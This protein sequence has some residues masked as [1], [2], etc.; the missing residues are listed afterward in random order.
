MAFNAEQISQDFG[1]P[2]IEIKQSLSS[3]YD[4]FSAIDLNYEF[5]NSNVELSNNN[6]D[7]RVELG[8]FFFEEDNLINDDF[9]PIIG[10]VIFRQLPKENL[11]PNGDC[12][13]FLNSFQPEIAIAAGS[14]L[15]FYLPDNHWGY[16]TYDGV[17]VSALAQTGEIT[18]DN[19][20]TAS[21]RTYDDG[22]GYD[23]QEHGSARHKGYVKN[24]EQDSDYVGPDIQGFSGFAGYFPYHYPIQHLL[25]WSLSNVSNPVSGFFTNAKAYSEGDY[26]ENQ[27]RK[28]HDFDFMDPYDF[29]NIAKWIKTNDAYSYGRCLEFRSKDEFE[30]TYNNSLMGSKF[31]WADTNPDLE[32]PSDTKLDFVWNDFFTDN[33]YNYNSSQWDDFVEECSKF[34]GILAPNSVFTI[35]EIPNEILKSVQEQIVGMFNLSAIKH[36]VLDRGFPNHS[37]DILQILFGDLGHDNC[38]IINSEFGASILDDFFKYPMETYFSNYEFDRQHFFGSGG[39]SRISGSGLHHNL[40]YQNGNEHFNINEINRSSKFPMGGSRNIDVFPNPP[41]GTVITPGIV[42]DALDINNIMYDDSGEDG[43]FEFGLPPLNGTD[44]TNDDFLPNIEHLVKNCY[45]F[46]VMGIFETFG[47]TSIYDTA[48]S[49][50]VPSALFQNVNYNQYRTLNHCVE[51]YHPWRDD[52]FLNPYSSLE[53]RFKMRTSA[54]GT[55][56]EGWENYP[57]GWDWPYDSNNPPTLEIGVV[58]HDTAIG[59][60]T[61]IQ[62]NVDGY[63]Y[64]KDFYYQPHGNF[65][66]IRYDGKLNSPN[67]LDAKTSLFGGGVRVTNQVVDEW[68][69]FSYIFNLA[70]F[71]SYWAGG[72]YDTAKAQSLIIQASGNFRGRV[73]VDDIEVFESHKFYPDVDVRKKKSAN[74]YGIGDLTEYYDPLL[75]PQE[76]EDT[77]GPLEAQFYF[78]PTYPTDEIFDIKRTPMYEEF[79]KGMFY[80]YDVDWGDGTP[81]EFTSKPEQISEEKALYHTYE[82]SGIFEVVG[83]MIRLKPDKEDN[84]LG[85]V[86]NQKFRLRI[87]IN[88]GLDEDFTYFGSDGFS[89]IPFKK[90][91]PILGGYSKQSI[92]YKSISR[93]LGFITDDIKTNIEFKND[94]QKLKTE[95]ALVKMDDKLKSSLDIL[96]EYTTPRYIGSTLINNGL[97]VLESELG[98]S[99][100]DMDMT[101]IKCYNSQKSMPELL[102]FIGDG[103]VA[104]PGSKRYWKNIISKNYTLYDREGINMQ[105][106]FPINTSSEQ[107]WVISNEGVRPYYPVLPKYGFDGKF[108]PNNFPNQ[109]IPFPQ[110]GPITEENEQSRD[111]IINLSSTQNVENN[112]LDDNSGNKNLGFAFSDFKPKFDNKTLDVKKRKTLNRFT[113]TK[114]NGAF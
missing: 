85:I 21:L 14:D 58:D 5:K 25:N 46:L 52:E 79:K 82:T 92:Y 109:N 80:I 51:F 30:Y 26:D 94:G 84:P 27:Q 90:T 1:V 108:I 74:N 31:S 61:R 24:F 98:E 72:T 13:F 48:F 63:G 18:F 71:N 37:Y 88:E 114:T 47:L 39:M 49:S 89:F 96:N 68:E 36:G 97:T 83:Y 22:L 41:A 77:T 11:I 19:I 76:Y 32:N 8:M 69:Q 43:G 9:P 34:P 15:E 62:D 93:Q 91:T 50:I 35:D 44:Y 7:G 104:N 95:L 23:S 54:A 59:I 101:S 86:Y 100:G 56:D 87:N 70:T 28:S 60:P 17:G 2:E 57:G 110:T 38:G 81:K 78:Y 40:A 55:Y 33:P 16:C 4:I 66:S 67:T 106:Q 3:S 105:N 102:G 112:V 29:S 12:K 103:E 45:P 6:Q 107:E 75:Q 64:P 42:P 113:S 20:A 10:D 99:I 65:H 111:L 73:L 53:I